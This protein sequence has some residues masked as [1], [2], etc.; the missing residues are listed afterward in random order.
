MWL[1]SVMA[2]LDHSR[3]GSWLL[4]Y[5]LEIDLLDQELISLFRIQIILLLDHQEL[6]GWCG[7]CWTQKEILYQFSCGGCS[8]W[9]QIQ[10][11]IAIG[12]SNLEL[13]LTIE[14]LLRWSLLG[15]KCHWILQQIIL[16]HR[17]IVELIN[18]W[19]LSRRGKL[20]A[21]SS[22]PMVAGHVLFIRRF[23]F[24]FTFF[25]RVSVN[26]A[27]T[28]ISFEH[29]APD[30]FFLGMRTDINNSWRK[31]IP[32]LTWRHLLR[33]N[34]RSWLAEVLCDDRI[35][36][37]TISLLPSRLEW[38]IHACFMMSF[39]CLSCWVKSDVWEGG[40]NLH[41]MWT[42]GPESLLVCTLP[43]FIHTHFWLC[44]NSFWYFGLML[45]L[46]LES[47][48]LVC[49]SAFGVKWFLSLLETFVH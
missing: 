44:Q 46:L 20:F 24:H 12:A 2:H 28:I 26:R 6:L 37:E 49:V 23:L 27:H 30:L 47:T 33:V 11:I 14:S 3:R 15:A 5:F 32:V 13:I 4:E 21:S 48:I 43:W 8:S 29:F 17:H 42:R 45:F 16:H 18:L 19:M 7:L 25:A 41:G 31:L 1:V 22:N 36:S 34:D 38:S 39:L 9:W 40:G 35:F 10:N